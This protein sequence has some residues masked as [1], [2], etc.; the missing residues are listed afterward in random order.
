MP[1]KR[2]SV[3]NIKH[4][5]KH[6]VLIINLNAGLQTKNEDKQHHQTTK[7]HYVI[8]NKNTL[9]Y[10][11]GFNNKKTY[12]LGFEQTKMQFEISNH[13]KYMPQYVQLLPKTSSLTS[14]NFSGPTSISCS[15][16]L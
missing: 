11:K 16:V 9:S 10:H 15:T 5:H 3:H 8:L 1:T 7:T 6:Q 4:K 12:G 14:F 13:L 2:V